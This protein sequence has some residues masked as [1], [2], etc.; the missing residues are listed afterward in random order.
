MVHDKGK[1][2]GV[3]WQRNQLIKLVWPGS[4]PRDHIN[5][6]TTNA[7]GILLQF[8]EK[9]QIECEKYFQ[10]N[11]LDYFCKNVLF[12]LYFFPRWFSDSPWAAM[13]Y[14]C[15]HSSHLPGTSFSLLM[16]RIC[17]TNSNEKHNIC[18][19]KCI[20]LEIM[21]VSRY[22]LLPYFHQTKLYCILQRPT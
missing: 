17:E 8:S 16:R 18:W 3:W 20:L 19:G 9:C 22:S 14:L 5:Y 7:S 15:F 13:A 10:T 1:Y 11:T 12:F 4:N 21:D 2:A 6:T